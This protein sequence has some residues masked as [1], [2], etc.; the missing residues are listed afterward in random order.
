MIHIQL[1]LI[2]HQIYNSLNNGFE[3]HGVFLDIPNV[4]HEGRLGGLLFKHFEIGSSRKTQIVL[5]NFLT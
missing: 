5:Q 4:F 2:T 3:V 1:Y